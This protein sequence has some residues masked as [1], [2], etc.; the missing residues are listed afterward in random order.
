VTALPVWN[1]SGRRFL[2]VGG[3][4]RYVG[5]DDGLVRYRGR[6]ESNVSDYFV[7]ATLEGV[8]TGGIPADHANH[9]GAELL[10]NQ[11]PVS[12]LGE[13]AEAQVSSVEANDPQFRGYY[14]TASWVVT[15][16]HRPYDKKV[17]YARRV[18]PAHRWGALELIARY[19]IVDCTDKGIDGGYMKKW[20]VAANW[21]ATRRWRF[22][23]GYGQGTLDKD[24]LVGKTDQT[25]ARVQWIF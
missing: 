1:E 22:S 12:V 16:E 5:A 13:Y 19:G 2:H 21:W 15:G 10:W 17:G 8:D 4:W 23:L 20:F 24:A 25:L 3:T 9:W 7:D 18:M 14:A 6:M 11:G